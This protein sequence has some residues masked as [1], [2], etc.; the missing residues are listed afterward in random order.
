M[1]ADWCKARLHS[2]FLGERR[3]LPPSLHQRALQTGPAHAVLPLP[4]HLPSCLHL[5]PAAGRGQQ[6]A[7]GDGGAAGRL[8]AVHP[9]AAGGGGRGG[10]GGLLG[11]GKGWLAGL[12]RMRRLPYPAAHPALPLCSPP[13]GQALC[14]GGAAAW[15]EYG[16]QG[17]GGCGL[18]RG[19]RWPAAAGWLPGALLVGAWVRQAAI[20]G[21]PCTPAPFPSAPSCR[22]RT[23]CA[24]RTP[25][26]T[27]SSV[28]CTTTSEP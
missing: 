1:G 13:P 11:D 9:G 25:T 6:P 17:R 26:P 5:L 24:R 14:V 16:P 3:P 23:S 10:W 20:P 12:L 15:R 22:R 18:P 21:S 28:R 2:R 4:P 27:P 7:G 8:P 19:N